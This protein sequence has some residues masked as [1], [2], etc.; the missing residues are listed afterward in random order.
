MTNI[1]ITGDLF[2][3]NQNH[4]N[5]LE[6]ANL[7]PI[8]IK[9]NSADEETLINTINENKIEGYIIGGVEQVTDRVLKEA[10]T[11]KSIVFT[12]TDYRPYVPGIQTAK[13]KN[14]SIGNVVGTYVD[15]VAEIGL[16]QMISVSRRAALLQRNAT[17]SFITT[18]SLIESH[19]GLL[20]G[21]L[22]SIR[23]VEMLTGIGVKKISYANRSVSPRMEK[24]GCQKLP[25]EELCKEVDVLTILIAYEAGEVLTKE[26]IDNIPTGSGI[27]NL[28]KPS[29]FDQQALAK[30][31]NK[32]ELFGY[33]DYTP[34][35]GSLLDS[36]PTV[37]QYNCESNAFNTFSSVD[38]C[39]VEAIKKLVTLLKNY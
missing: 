26:F 21:G 8:F 3:Q 35:E 36:D 9:S 4:L 1:L 17:E 18:K 7:N 6:E 20:G 28:S 13:D 11:L 23:L 19:V 37:F 30:R 2:L 34:T 27:V 25:V 10:N 31:V 38:A 16:A 24:L 14:I 5:Q 32:R 33:S 15:S 22:T 12:G 29:A 39:S